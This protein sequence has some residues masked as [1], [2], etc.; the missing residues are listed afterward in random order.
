MLRYKW[1]TS[2]TKLEFWWFVL[3]KF[4][5]INVIHFTLILFQFFLV[6]SLFFYILK[7]PSFLRKQKPKRSK[8]FFKYS[9]KSNSISL[10]IIWFPLAKWNLKLF[11]IIFIFLFSQKKFQFNI[12]FQFYFIFYLSKS[13]TNI[14][15][16]NI[17]S[18][19][20]LFI[21]NR[22]FLVFLLVLDVAIPRFNLMNSI[23]RLTTTHITS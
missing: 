20:N 16:N 2:T 19:T 7:K 10:W 15:A 21:V 4:L 23:V 17:K 18:I 13:N 14:D 3:F 11:Y 8:L 5:P 12:I 22:K 9:M 6:V 1:K